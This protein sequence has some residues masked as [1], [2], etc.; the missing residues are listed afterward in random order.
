MEKSSFYTAALHLDFAPW[1]KQNHVAR[2]TEY[3]EEQN[4]QR[5]TLHFETTAEPCCWL[6]TLVDPQTRERKKQA[7]GIKKGA[8]E[9]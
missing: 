1:Q 5:R 9:E 4:A 8:L 2:G 7:R 6:Q 3:Q